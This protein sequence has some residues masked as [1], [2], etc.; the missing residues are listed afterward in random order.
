MLLPDLILRVNLAALVANYGIIATQASG[1]Q[2]SAVVKANAYGLGV[3]PVVNAL[4]AAGCSLFFVATLEEALEVRSV[5]SGVAIAFFHGCIDAKQ[6]QMAKQYDL[7]PVVN[8]MES[9]ALVKDIP[10]IIHIDTGMNRL[11]IMHQMVDQIT[12]SQKTLYMITHPAC[13]DEEQH[14]LNVTQYSIFKSCVARFPHVKVSYANSSAIFSSEKY[15]FDLVRP[16]AALYGVNPNPKAENPM[17]P[18]ITLQSRILQIRRI[19][20]P[21]SVGYGA[22]KEVPKGTVLATLGCGYADGILRSTSKQGVAVVANKRCKIIGRISMDLIVVDVTQVQNEVVVGEYAELI[23]ESLTID[24]VASHA[25]TIGY[26]ILTRL[27][28]RCYRIYQS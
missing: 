13:A 14:P 25:G 23:G 7:I 16:G 24:E 5:T 21:S 12:I 3:Q 20:T 2:C 15:H 10:H 8:T 4:E 22:T 26:E 27:G 9:L 17:R 11:G 6:A 1:A 18:V 28:S 19:D